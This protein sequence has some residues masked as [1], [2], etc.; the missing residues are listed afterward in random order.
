MANHY[1]DNDDL[2]FYV[3]NAIDWA[4]LLKLMDYDGGPRR[5]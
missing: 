1:E 5:L 4:P 2:R 3:E